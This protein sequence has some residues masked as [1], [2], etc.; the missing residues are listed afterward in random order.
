MNQGYT[1]HGTVRDVSD[2]AKTEHLRALER[3]HANAGGKVVLFPADLGDEGAFDAAAEGCWGL[4]HLASVVVA[5][6]TSAEEQV[7][8]ASKGTLSALEAAKRGGVRSVVVTASTVTISPSRGKLSAEGLSWQGG[9]SDEGQWNDVATLD[10]GTY[11]FSKVTAERAALAWLAGQGA[12]GPF[13]YATIHFPL[14]LGPQLD[15]RVTSSNNVVSVL[16]RGELPFVLPMQFNVV[17]IRDVARAHLH[18]LEHPSASGRYLVANRPALASLSFPEIAG[19]LRSIGGGA[20]AA[21]PIPR[22]EAPMWLARLLAL[23]DSRVDPFVLESSARGRHPGY[24]ADRIVAELGFAYRFLDTDATLLD[25]AQSM[26]YQGIAT[27]KPAPSQKLWVAASMLIGS[28]VALLQLAR[29][30]WRAAAGSSSTGPAASLK[31]QRA[32]GAAAAGGK[33]KRH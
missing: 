5:H 31:A 10:F 3:R 25:T 8:L 33:P 13:R 9:P 15:R 29:L 32:A 1:V 18:V 14:G 16:L 28:L 24:V 26:V 11:S 21:F 2:E 7:R 17:D 20:F 22:Y 27:G 19:K 30:C 6:G 4:L 12:P 23:V